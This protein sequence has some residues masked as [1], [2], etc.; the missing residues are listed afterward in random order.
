[1]SSFCKCSYDM[2]AKE[3]NATP[4]VARDRKSVV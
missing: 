4:G 3:A 2:F 1:M